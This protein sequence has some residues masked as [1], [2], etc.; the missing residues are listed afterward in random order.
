MGAI[1]QALTDKDFL[2]AHPD[3]QKK[4]LSS[5]DPD[6]AKG[7]PQDQQAYL[8]HILEPTRKATISQSGAQFEKVNKMQPNERQANSFLLGAAS[9]ASGLPETLHPIHDAATQS[10]H[11]I[12]DIAKE[13]LK[14]SLGPLP[15]VA[16][17]LYN[18]GKEALTPAGKNEDPEDVSERRAH[19]VG[20]G[21]GMLAPIALGEGVERAPGEI[22]GATRGLAKLG[23]DVTGKPKPIVKLAL[24]GERSRALA[25]LADPESAAY[26]RKAQDFMRRGREQDAL[27][28][29]AASGAKA[30]AKAEPPTPG[31][32]EGPA[33]PTSG[34]VK[35]PIP[36]ELT[37]GEKVGY[38]ASTPRKLLVNN[39]LQGR[40]GAGD[41]LRNIGLS[42]LYVG[43]EMGGGPRERISLENI[44]KST[45]PQPIPERRT[46]TANDRPQV[47][48]RP[49]EKAVTMSE[50]RK[51]LGREFDEGEMTHDIERSKSILRNPRATAEDRQVAQSR[52]D[53]ALERRAGTKR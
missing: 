53:E 37:P 15:S 42:P 17:S 24:G 52:L 12:G 50:E 48:Y 44:G 36:R 39:A 29:R 8:N 5:V 14:A 28:R 27:D 34:V 32:T 16:S 10:P 13:G 20:S 26:E 31:P 11:S 41:M 1:A 40:P 19:A 47:A 25:E 6:F 51:P 22:G 30:A 3:D 21:V 7:S 49:S 43:E 45:E 46:G 2:N 23:T 33:T 18:I 9:G 38:N 35:I 4:Y